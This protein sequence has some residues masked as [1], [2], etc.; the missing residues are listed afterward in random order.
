[1][2]LPKPLLMYRAH[3]DNSSNYSAVVFWAVVKEA[4]P[5][6]PHVPLI[7]LVGSNLARRRGDY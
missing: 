5:L 2:Y 7:F 4:E 3:S 1:M 6:S